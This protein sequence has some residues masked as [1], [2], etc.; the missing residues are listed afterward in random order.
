MKKKCGQNIIHGRR[1]KII[2]FFP[3]LFILEGIATVHIW[4]SGNNLDE[5][6]LTLQ[7]PRINSNQADWKSL[8]SLRYLTDPIKSLFKSCLRV[9]K[10]L[11]DLEYILLLQRGLSLPSST[12]L[13]ISQLP[14]SGFCRHGTMNACYKQTHKHTSFNNKF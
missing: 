8:Y 14:W 4:R 3:F 13:D 2:S 6:I 7:A 11:S 9:W 1:R 12:M 10:W 5:W